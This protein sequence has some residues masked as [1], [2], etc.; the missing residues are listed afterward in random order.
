MVTIYDIFEIF[1]ET[2]KQLKPIEILRKLKKQKSEYNNIFRL[3]KQLTNL[4]LIKK[5][6][7]CYIIK[8]SKKSDLLKD[9][10]RYSSANGIN[11]NDI[12]NK[13]LI[14]FIYKSIQTKKR[15]AQ[16]LKINS[17]TFIKYLKTLEKYGLVL[18][19]SRK[20][21]KFEIFYNPLINNLFLYFE[22]QKLSI[23]NPKINYT[24]N[25][26]KELKIFRRLKKKNEKKFLAI[27]NEF[28][29]TFVYHSL[30]LEGNPLTLPQTIKILKD[31]FIPKNIY[32][33]DI[34]ELE[35]Y[36]K[37]ISKMIIDSNYGSKLNLN[38]ILDYHKIAMNHNHKLAGK[39]RKNP[40]YIKGNP[41]FIVS[42]PSQIE[43]SLN[44]LIKK[45][46]DFLEIKKYEIYEIIK[47][48]AFFHNEFQYIHPF[49]DGNSRISR[50]LLFHLLNSK[51]IPILDIP[52]GM[53]NEYLD[54]TKA[55]KK[56]IDKEL[57]IAL[58]KIILFNLKKINEKLE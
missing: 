14:S 44:S 24:T 8:K 9:I 25:I 19:I 15:S 54:S 38:I 1:S 12:L 47:F 57:T 33:Y 11:Y 41:N 6:S 31:K 21:I 20:P 37:A 30:S 26:K 7:N 40:V 28:E 58:Q 23:K 50:L 10:I 3:I 34:K 29:I 45:Y 52:F 32:H 42:K 2:N 55:S 13:K 27:V 5:Q 53:L 48:S 17:K 4:N 35:N 49:T 18:I 36:K 39:L 51:N 56:R 46:N 43:E 16:D 22:Y